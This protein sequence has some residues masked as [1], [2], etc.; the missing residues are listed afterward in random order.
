VPHRPVAVFIDVCDVA[1]ERGIK[2]VERSTHGISV[3]RQSDS[4]FRA[5]A[6]SRALAIV[7]A[8]GRLGKVVGQ[9]A[10]KSRGAGGRIYGISGCV[11]IPIADARRL[12][13][14]PTAPACPAIHWRPSSDARTSAP[15]SPR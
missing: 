7:H 13:Q 11:G 15:Y 6:S 4:T 8:T 1:V 10:R 14:A 5:K 9:L 12:N 3:K 2:D